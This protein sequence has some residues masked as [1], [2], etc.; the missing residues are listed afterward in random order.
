MSLFYDRSDNFGSGIAETQISDWKPVYGSQVSFES[1]L[2]GSKYLDGY[3]K[4]APSSLNNLTANFNMR[5]DVNASDAKKIARCI[6]RIIPEN[7]Y[8]VIWQIPSEFYQQMRVE[9]KNYAINHISKNHYEVAVSLEAN[10][11]CPI[12]DW[13]SLSYLK[14]TVSAFDSGNAYEKYDICT[15]GSNGLDRFYYATQDSSGTFSSNNWSQEFFF[16]PDI[17]M[18]NEVNMNVEQFGFNNSFKT[19]HAS[20]K[21]TSAL[22]LS[23]KFSNIKENHAKCLLHFLESKAG[24]RRFLHQPQSIYTERP[25]VFFAPSWTHTFT[26]YNS[27]D[28]QVKLIEDPLGVIPVGQ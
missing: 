16:K 1:S 27:H 11:G 24:Y 17:G 6:E 25:K 4:F 21:H 10:R 23:Y 28:I 12:L 19:Y 8:G 22:E 13:Q 18:Q 26:Q 7:S 9:C 5:Y 2:V 3:Q 15:R 14:K 20:Q